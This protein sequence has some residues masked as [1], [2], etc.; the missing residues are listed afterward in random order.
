MNYHH[1]SK[2]TVHELDREG[3]PRRKT[4]LNMKFVVDERICDG[5]VYAIG[6]KHIKSGISKPEQ[7]MERPKEV[8][9]DHIDRR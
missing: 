9:H 1:G 7:L 5:F 3:R 4:Y 8:F 2:E 6:F